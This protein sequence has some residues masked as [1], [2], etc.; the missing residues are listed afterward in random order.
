LR[1]SAHRS[2]VQ[3]Y[4]HACNAPEEAHEIYKCTTG[5][6]CASFCRWRKTRFL[7]MRSQRASCQ[8]AAGSGAVAETCTYTARSSK[9]LARA[10]QRSERSKLLS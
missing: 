10:C 5:E 4:G 7:F 3:H 8:T 9:R 2:V 6:Y 1:F